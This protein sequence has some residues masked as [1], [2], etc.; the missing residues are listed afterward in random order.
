MKRLAAVAVAAALLLAAVPAGYAQSMPAGDAV[1]VMDVSKASNATM[2]KVDDATFTTKTT[3]IENDLL[4]ALSK[5]ALINQQLKNSGV[6]VQQV[7]AVTKTDDGALNI[8]Y[9]E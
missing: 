6:A 1:D 3:A 7:V 2:F 9:E 8:Y 5:N 4:Q